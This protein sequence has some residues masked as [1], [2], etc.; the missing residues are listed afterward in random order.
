VVSEPG[1]QYCRGR[2][3]R[4]PASTTS[5]GQIGV[6]IPEHSASLVRLILDTS[7]C[8]RAEIDKI[9]RTEGITAPQMGLMNRIAVEPGRSAAALARGLDLTPQAVGPTLVALHG[10]GLVT[11]RM[12]SP[13]GR[14]IPTYLT[15]AGQALLDRCQAAIRA[16]NARVD[17]A[18]SPEDHERVSAVLRTILSSDAF[19]SAPS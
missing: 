12:E 18:M 7:T 6:A 10:K 17:A 11:R 4:R 2:W 8:L 19:C 3:G 5:T 14:A 9:V 15:P 13:E 16:L 1:A